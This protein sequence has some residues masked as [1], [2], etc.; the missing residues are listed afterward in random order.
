MQMTKIKNID[1]LNVIKNGA[2]GI[3]QGLWKM[4][5]SN[6]NQF[7]PYVTATLLLAILL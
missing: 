4:I 6:K 7:L 5:V 1:S 3:V 2:F